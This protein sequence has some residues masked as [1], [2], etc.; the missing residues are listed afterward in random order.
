MTDSDT[1]TP[2][3][4][5]TKRGLPVYADLVDLWDSGAADARTM[6]GD[7]WQRMTVE[8]TGEEC[9]APFRGGECYTASMMAEPRRRQIIKNQAERE[10]KHAGMRP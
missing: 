1:A 10:R 4:V 7:R 6:R 5:G 3:P 8:G 2:A 9:L